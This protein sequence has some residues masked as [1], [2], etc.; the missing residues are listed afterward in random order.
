[1]L[2][3]LPL[4]NM[5]DAWHTEEERNLLFGDTKIGQLNTKTRLLRP[6]KSRK[7]LY[8]Q[9]RFVGRMECFLDSGH[10]IFPGQGTL[11]KMGQYSTCLGAC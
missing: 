2:D 3:L 6:A 5:G 4:E 8:F 11:L 1:M 7:I 9:I 10:F